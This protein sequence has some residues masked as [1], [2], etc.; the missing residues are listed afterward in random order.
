VRIGSK[1]QHN[2]TCCL[3]RKIACRLKALDKEDKPVKEIR[4][5]KKKSKNSHQDSRN[6]IFS[7]SKEIGQIPT[8]ASFRL[9]KYKVICD[10][11]P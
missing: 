8:I 1:N 10:T 2:K 11:F 9:E 6:D 3:V 4:V 5:I 7:A